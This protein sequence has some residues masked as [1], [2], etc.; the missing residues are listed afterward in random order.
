MY[1]IGIDLGGTKILAGVVS[2]EGKVIKKM[3]VMTQ[4]HRDWE[5]IGDEIVKCVKKI[6]KSVGLSLSDIKRIGIGCP[7]TI[8]RQRETILIAPNL[9]WK[10]VPFRKYLH[11][12]INIPVRLENDV[13]LGTLGV[14][15]FGEGKGVSSLIG[16]FVG[17]GIGAGIVMNGDLYIGYDGTAGEFGHMVIDIDG[18]ECGCG[19]RGCWEKLASRITI[20]KKIDEYIK[21]EGKN[22]EVGRLF[23]RMKNKGKAVIEGYKMGLDVVVEA[24]DETSHFI[25]IGLGNIMT[26]FNPEMIALGGGII[27]DLGEFMIPVIKKIS[28]KYAIYGSAK[29]VKIIHTSLGSDAVMLGAAAWAM[30]E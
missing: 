22:T 3:M 12:K 20:Y 2:S 15:Y 21:K 19:N 4:R 30:K 25:G 29:G 13:N 17:T 24:V 26:M 18:P 28:K 11:S 1:Y 6:V 23:S 7:G 10:N 8:D 5:K 14:S 16:I 9:H 27:D